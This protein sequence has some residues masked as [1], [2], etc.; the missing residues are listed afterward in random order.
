MNL[1]PKE[2]KEALK[3]AQLKGHINT[4][5]PSVDADKLFSILS[6]CIGEIQPT[7]ADDNHP[8]PFLKFR[9]DSDFMKVF[10]SSIIEKYN[11][12]DK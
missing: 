8:N 12:T 4:K 3:K 5:Y 9:I 2:E 11:K 7:G 6:E 1:L 10:I